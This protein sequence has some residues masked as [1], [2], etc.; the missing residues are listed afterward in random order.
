[1]PGDDRPDPKSIA[2]GDLPALMRRSGVDPTD[3]WSP[4]LSDLAGV[5]ESHFRRVQR[6]SDPRGDAEAVISVI[7]ESLG[8]VQVYIPRADQLRRA[9]RDLRIAAEF[10]GSNIAELARR[11]RLSTQRVRAILATAARRRRCE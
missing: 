9:L 5:L 6:S 4:L 3:Y 10:D 8:G 7:A 1:M 11:H 2:A